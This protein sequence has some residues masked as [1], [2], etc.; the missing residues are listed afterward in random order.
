MAESTGQAAT[1]RER[2]HQEAAKVRLDPRF[3]DVVP[4][5]CV[6][7]PKV[8]AA[9]KRGGMPVDDAGGFAV[10]TFLVTAPVAP[11]ETELTAFCARMKL[12][13][14]TRVRALV[15]RFEK[16][17]LVERRRSAMDARRVELPPKPILR[18]HFRRW[19]RTLAGLVE[20]WSGIGAKRVNDALVVEYLRVTS[21][22]YLEG[23]VLFQDFPIVARF[24]ARRSGYSLFLTLIGRADSKGL[25]TLNRQQF[26]ADHAASR[27]HI[28]SLV[29]EAE[30]DG[31]LE[32]AGGDTIRLSSTFT[33][34]AY[35]WLASE[36]V[37]TSYSLL[38][39]STKRAAR[40]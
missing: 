3:A 22:A 33:E 12:A 11:T 36:V 21:S 19:I 10:A 17:G 24:Q 2:L 20:P 18:V 9:L 38:Q 1:F 31:L 35:R 16:E 40:P 27:P 29:K 8:W 30:A 28:T 14:R 15:D 23:Y 39:A 25:T 13:S 34:E 26:A 5:F 4:K 32:R 6:A 37:W 7:I